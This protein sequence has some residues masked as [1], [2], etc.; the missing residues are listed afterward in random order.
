MVGIYSLESGHNL[1]KIP[2]TSLSHNML[3][4][5]TGSSAL[6]IKNNIASLKATDI[7]MK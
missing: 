7:V 3:Q 2:V 6:A 5:M 1:R 4:D